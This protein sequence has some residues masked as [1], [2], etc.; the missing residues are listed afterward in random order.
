MLA[1]THDDAKQS[2]LHLLAK[3]SFFKGRR[4]NAL[5]FMLIA[6]LS[7]AAL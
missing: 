2:L 7:V 3:G 4:G 1:L 5:D 6:C